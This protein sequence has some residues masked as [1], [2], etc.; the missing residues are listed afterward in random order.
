MSSSSSFE[1]N[2]IAGAI[3]GTLMLSLGL[4]IVSEEYFKS[5]K[6]AKAGYELLPGYS[7]R[8][9]WWVGPRESGIDRKST[10]LNSSHNDLSR[11]PSSA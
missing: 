10:R 5:E 2:K 11:M 8:S 7:Y 9:M 4:G 6:P 1:L 3:L